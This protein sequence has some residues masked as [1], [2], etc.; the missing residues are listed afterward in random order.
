MFLGFD[1]YYVFKIQNS[2]LT[3]HLAPQSR[4]VKK[5]VNPSS[6]L[7]VCFCSDVILWELHLRHTS[8]ASF[9]L[10]IDSSTRP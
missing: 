2:Q 6:A 5:T 9:L 10:T 8:A 3:F 7:R 1:E 4:H